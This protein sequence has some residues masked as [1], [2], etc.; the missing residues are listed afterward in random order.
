[1]GSYSLLYLIH[2]F[3]N[4]LA[5]VPTT[6][7]MTST[8]TMSTWYRE[9]KEPDKRARQLMVITR[10][11][12]SRIARSAEPKRWSRGTENAEEHAELSRGFVSEPYRKQTLSCGDN[13]GTASSS[14]FC[15][16][17]SRSS[18]SSPQYAVFPFAISLNG[19]S[20]GAY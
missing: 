11:R 17:S 10:F 7:T 15:H 13:G 9:K 20:A 1:M 14:P 5:D 16:R 19:R 6:T 8:T 12:A 3:A 2:A 4:K 18:R